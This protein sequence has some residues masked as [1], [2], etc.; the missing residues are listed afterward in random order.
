[1]PGSWRELLT[2]EFG[3][4]NQILWLRCLQIFS[5]PENRPRGWVEERDLALMLLISSVPEREDPG[6]GDH[7][8]G[9]LD[10][11]DMTH[12]KL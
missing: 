2:P 12:H 6:S 9:G 3:P 5:L 1:M 11:K 8:D 10:A 7:A 4:H